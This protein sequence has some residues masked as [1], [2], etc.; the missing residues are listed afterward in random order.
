MATRQDS[1]HCGRIAFALEGD[2]NRDHGRQLFAAPD[3][4]SRNALAQNLPDHFGDPDPASR[5]GIARTAVARK[6]RAGVTA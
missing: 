1:C 3:A 4:A 5:D 6:A 2:I